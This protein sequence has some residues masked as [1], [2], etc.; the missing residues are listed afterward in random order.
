[1]KSLILV[2]LG[3]L[4]LGCNDGFTGKKLNL[5]TGTNLSP[6]PYNPTPAPYNPSPTPTHDPE[7]TPTSGEPNLN[8]DAEGFVR[9]ERSRYGT[10]TRDEIVNLLRAVARQLNAN[11]SAGPFGILKKSGGTNCGGYSCD[12]IC[13]GQGDNQKQWDVLGDAGGASTPGWGYIDGGI[14]VDVC[15]IQ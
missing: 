6:S 14:R 13:T 4:L 10:P 15:E 1:M 9:A 7:P 5:K 12:V 3:F 11:C 2:V 8:C